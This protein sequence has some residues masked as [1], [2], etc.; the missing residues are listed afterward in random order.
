MA[1][2]GGPVKA[3]ENYVNIE[4]NKINEWTKNNKTR[5][6]DKKSKVMLVSRRKK[7][8]KQKYNSIPKQQKTKASNT[9]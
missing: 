4:L 6:K 9:D 5:F 3:V 1:T 8:R 2:K 7:K